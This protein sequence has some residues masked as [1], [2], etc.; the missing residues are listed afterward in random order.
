MDN[1]RNKLLVMSGKGG[2][3]K[4][5]IAVNL[6]YSLS[7][8][9]LKVGLLDIDVHGPN[10][11]KML[12]LENKKLEAKNNKMVPIKYKNSL[13]VMSMAFL[14]KKENAGIWRGPMKHNIIKQFLDDVE[15]GK[16]DY[17]IVDLPPGTGDEPL[18]ISQLLK[19]I[20]GTVIVSTPQEVALLDGI[21]SVDF[22]KKLKVP[23]LGLIENMSGEIFGEGGVEETAKKQK[24]PFIGRIELDAR[25]RK[26][27][28]NG[29]PSEIKELFSVIAGK[30]EKICEGK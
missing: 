21:K 16:L 12:N 4:T 15:W 6:A 22:S 24:I 7:E 19:N 25:I 10:V 2:V 30:I 28:D 18:S 26:S 23:I 5:T 14:L 20:T 3:G 17:L 13:K 8:K 27:G 1:I 9:G 29:D 11:A